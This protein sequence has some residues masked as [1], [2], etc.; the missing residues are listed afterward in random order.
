MLRDRLDVSVDSYFI[1]KMTIADLFHDAK[2]RGV[3]YV[4]VVGD[5]NE[6]TGTVNLNKIFRQ[7]RTEGSSLSPPFSL[8]QRC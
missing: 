8:D 3:R 1:E 7:G 4:L 2:R 6:Q 5:Q